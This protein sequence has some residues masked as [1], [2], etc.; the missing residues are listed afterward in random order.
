[1]IPPIELDDE[2]NELFEA[3]MAKCPSLRDEQC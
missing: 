3:R 1:L 2:A